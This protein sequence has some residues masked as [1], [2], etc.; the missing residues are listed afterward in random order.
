MEDA[1]NNLHAGF[2]AH[3]CRMDTRSLPASMLLLNAGGC[4]GAAAAAADESPCRYTTYR[5]DRQVVVSYRVH[6]WLPV[7]VVAL[8]PHDPPLG[9]LQ[10]LAEV[11]G[12]LRHC[13]KGT[14]ST[15]QHA[16]QGL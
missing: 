1:L 9:C 3:K 10:Q 4:V 6:Q 5:Q 14:H 13:R 11:R 7:C 8:V 12:L 16:T 2:F 15:P